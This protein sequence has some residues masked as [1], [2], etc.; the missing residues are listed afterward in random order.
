MAARG[1][2]VKITEGEQ[3]GTSKES[4]IPTGVFGGCGEPSGLYYNSGPPEPTDLEE[5]RALAEVMKRCLLPSGQPLNH[6]AGLKG[7]GGR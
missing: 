1:L 5:Q 4:S 3:S 6:T 7:T 2:V